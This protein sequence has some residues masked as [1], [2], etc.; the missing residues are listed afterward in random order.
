MWTDGLV[1]QKLIDTAADEIIRQIN[2]NAWG[3]MNNGERVSDQFTYIFG[4][5]IL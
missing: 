2:E 4:S 1:S 5:N 3:I